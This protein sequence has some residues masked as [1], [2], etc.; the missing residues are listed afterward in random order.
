MPTHD[1]LF[2]ILLIGDSNVGKS[3]V[4]L[5]FTGSPFSESVP[6]TI[7]V[8]FRSKTVTSQ[9]GSVCLLNIWDTAGQEQFRSL[10]SSYYRGTHGIVLVYDAARQAS[11]ESLEGWLTEA[12]AHSTLDDVVFAVVA[13][14]ID[15]VPS[16]E[17]PVASERGAAFARSIGAVFIEC[18]A[19][20]SV[21]IDAVFDELLEQILTTPSLCTRPRDLGDRAT[22]NAG[23]GGGGGDGSSAHGQASYC[24]T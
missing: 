13:N 20:T 5:R 6:T 14:K 24:C 3:S 4:L 18:S 9:T 22:L 15:L 7:G 16:A 8:D 23:G 21:G 11:F 2:K 17:A 10:T 19:K 12:R 1:F